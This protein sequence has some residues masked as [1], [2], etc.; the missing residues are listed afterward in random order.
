MLPFK[1]MVND[2]LSYWFN[3]FCILLDVGLL[4]IIVCKISI[5]FNYGAIIIFS[6]C[7]VILGNLWV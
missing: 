6:F 1:I 5:R 7:E 2:L 3:I 4:Y